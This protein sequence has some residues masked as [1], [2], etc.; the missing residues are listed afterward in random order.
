MLGNCSHR[1]FKALARAIAPAAIMVPHRV[2]ASQESESDG[3]FSFFQISLTE[4]GLLALTLIMIVLVISI[5]NR[6]Y[7]NKHET[8]FGQERSKRNFTLLVGAVCVSMFVSILVVL[9]TEKSNTINSYHGRLDV[10]QDGIEIILQEWLGEKATNLKLLIDEDFVILAQLLNDIS[11]LDFSEEEK[12][13]ILSASP[14]NRRLQQHVI[15]RIRLTSTAGFTLIGQSNINLASTSQQRIGLKNELE[16]SA[17]QALEKAWQGEILLVPPVRSEEND[18]ELTPTPSMF[19]LYPVRD[20]QNEVFALFSLTIDPSRGFSRNF[21]VAKVGQSGRVYGVDS[22]GYIISNAEIR[23][24]EEILSQKVSLPVV[25]AIHDAKSQGGSFDVNLESLINHDNQQVLASV[26]WLPEFGIAALAEINLDEVYS[27]YNTT[28]FVLLTFLIIATSLILSVSFFLLRVGTRSHEIMTQSNAELEQQ[29]S[30]RTKELKDKQEELFHVLESSPIAV[31]IIQNDFPVYTNSRALELFQVKAQDIENYDIYRIYKY[32]SQREEIYKELLQ[33]KQVID[34]E[35]ELTKHTGET[36]IGRVSYYR[37]QFEG[38]DAV[39]FWAYDV[40]DLVELTNMLEHSREQ[41]RQANQ[42]KSQ[43]LAN[44]S[45]EIRTPMNA[46]I[47]MTHLAQTRN[48]QPAV[49]RYLGKVEQSASTLLNLIN[50]ILDISKIEAGKLELD[51]Q[52]FSLRE[53]TRKLADICSIKAIEKSIRLY[54]EIDFAVE[55]HLICDDTRLF[56]VL[57]NLS[58]NAI[59]F[60]QSGHVIIK[61]Q[62]IETN[63]EQQTLRFSVIDSGIGISEEQKS[64]L[65][66]SF[67]QADASTTRNFGGTGLGLSISKQLVEKMGGG[68]ELES[69]LGVGSTFS[70]ELD[71]PINQEFRGQWQTSVKANSNYHVWIQNDTPLSNR[72]VQASFDCLDT[73]VSF[74][75]SIQEIQARI[76]P[77]QRNTLLTVDKACAEDI[78]SLKTFVDTHDIKVVVS[79]D[80]DTKV[81]DFLNAGWQ[82]IPNPALPDEVFDAVFESSSSLLQTQTIPEAQVTFAGSHVLLVEDNDINQELALGLLEPF[83]IEVDVANNGQQALECIAN[84]N[85]DLVLMDIQMP[86]MDG[87]EATEKLRDMGLELPIVA[88]TA[89]VMD[90]DIQRAKSA[91]FNDHLGKPIDLNK[92]QSTLSHYLRQ[93]VVTTKS[94]STSAI[95]EEYN[96]VF[97]PRLGLRTTN[98]NQDLYLKLLTKF[99]ESIQDKLDSLKKLV[100][101]GEYHNA[102]IVA[103][104]LKGLGA[105][106]GMQHL[107]ECAA[108]LESELGSP[109][110]KPHAFVP[111]LLSLEEAAAQCTIML[112]AYLASQGKGKAEP[113]LIGKNID[114]NQELTALLS[115]VE[116]YEFE[117]QERIESLLDSLIDVQLRHQL[118]GIQSAISNFDYES[119]ADKLKNL[120]DEQR[121]I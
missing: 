66:Q 59:K 75:D 72:L 115:A 120:I 108:K 102:E 74:F 18:T 54:F 67:Q 89:N 116:A 121:Q 36:F 52:P 45:H 109:Q 71:L 86:I 29:I 42:S 114:L 113:D 95:I 76:N 39:L 94:A 90:E 48:Q 117:A 68:L 38:Q 78:D 87:Y 47:G 46:I 37:T 100:T 80:Q 28:R 55:R 49:G 82:C 51:N 110:P 93:Q 30:H 19:L 65:F 40:S 1:I 31:S 14:I 79:T 8:F 17:S 83:E 25:Q 33:D 62:A 81:E 58:G 118:K 10:A 34:R 101:N 119:A 73:H 4:V 111:Q 53:L 69:E 61:I 43:F 104:T 107:G 20:E 57:L 16:T 50:D 35:M 27:V 23:S 96:T 21:R 6:L 85:Y 106:L 12:A 44:M 63:T 3:A 91:G 24:E 13:R 22:S 11:A 103:H 98:D 84:K 56:Q 70:F 2:T 105:S 60:T 92:L 97:D 5:F 88:M 112:D 9:K 99:R 41:E 15:S 7:R 32:R 26:R 64:R 77:K